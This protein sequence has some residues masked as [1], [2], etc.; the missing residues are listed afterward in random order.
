M[1]RA[2]AANAPVHVQWEPVQDA[3]Y[4]LIMTDPDAPSRYLP[5]LREIR[6]WLIVNIPGS[7]I[8]Q[9]EELASYIPPGPPIFTGL[10]R[11]IYLVYQQKN[12]RQNFDEKPIASRTERMRTSTQAFVD[13]NNLG[14]PIAGN[15]FQSKH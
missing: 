14:N 1:T 3:F 6:H 12:G 9:G 5:L 4:T 11:Y 15:F 10:H 13:K 2:E 7:A 8:D